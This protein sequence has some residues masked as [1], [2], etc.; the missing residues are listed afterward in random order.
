MKIKSITINNFRCYTSPKT[1]IFDELTLIIGKNDIGKS[2][3]LEAA[4]IFFGNRKP[5]KDDLPITCDPDADRIEISIEFEGHPE[6]IDI[7]AGAKTNLR[8]EYLLN[9]NGR[10]EVK[11]VYVAGKASKPKLLLKAST[12]KGKEVLVIKKNAELKKMASDLN[13]D[14]S[15]YNASVNNSIR[16][17]IWSEL[18]D[19][20][21]EE[22]EFEIN[23]E[24]G[25]KIYEKLE[26]EFPI[27]TLFSAD[28]KNTD[29]D[30]EIQTPIKASVKELVSALNQEL[31]P[32]KEKILQD[33]NSI[34]EGT[35]EKLS[36]MNPEVASSLKAIVEK[37]AW[38]KAFTVNIES[39]GI[40]LNKRGSGVKRL[41]LINFFRQEAERKR[42]AGNKSD[43][44]YAIEEPETSQ[45]PDWQIKLFEAFEELVND[46]S[47]QIAITSHHPELSG[48]VNL[49]NVRFIQK[50]NDEIIIKTGDETNCKEISKT[51]G[52]L[53]KLDGVKVIVGLE[54]PSDVE[55][56]SNIAQVFGVDPTDERILW[57]PLGGGT[58]RNYVDKGY[59][60]VLKLPQV[61]FF[62]RDEDNKYE[63]YAAELKGKD[64]WAEISSLLTI[65]NYFHPKYY[66]QIWTNLKGDYIEN[67]S[68][69]L[70]LSDWKEKDI[71]RELSTFITSESESG[72]SALDKC[73]FSNVKK[74]IARNSS[75]MTVDDFKEMKT[76]EEL[77][78]FFKEIKKN[79]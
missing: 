47:V 45:H 13:I 20:D 56:F 39:D 70:W 43:V 41:V 38:E 14:E 30:D 18:E 58:I 71:P 31:E 63:S 26:L 24:D 79:L 54:G 62:D 74:H 44:F 55:F 36:E 32:I 35:I 50:D 25:K 42:K 72:N 69:L 52:V 10:L 5:D 29:Q 67:I 6:E 11:K 34:A 23:K 78:T 59:L 66:K 3:I 61:Y 22:I 68:D 15:K 33:L 27:F 57:V 76:Y 75:L 40:P 49:N 17:A 19:S 46:N 51:L 12:P 8:D 53:P 60:E 16:K 77:S 65:E 37:P 28:R 1:I 64:H 7:D 4:D 73:N 21:L 48:L 9:T 2:T